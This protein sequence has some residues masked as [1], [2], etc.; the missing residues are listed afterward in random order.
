MKSMDCSLLVTKVSVSEK[1]VSL[2]ALESSECRFNCSAN[3]ASKVGDVKVSFTLDSSSGEMKIA[4][5]DRN[6]E[7]FQMIDALYQGGTAGQNG[8]ET[9]MLAVKENCLSK[10]KENIKRMDSSL[11]EYLAGKAE[12]Y[13]AAQNPYKRA[14]ALEYASTYALSRN[15]QFLDFTTL[16]G[17]CQNY[18]SQILRAGGIPNDMDGEEKWKYY[19]DAYDITG[20]AKGRTPSW[21]SVTGFLDYAQK[22]T[23]YGLSAAVGANIFTLEGGDLIICTDIRGEKVHTLAAAS[24]IYD[25]AGNAADILTFSSSI[26]RKNYPL[27]AYCYCDYTGIKILGWNE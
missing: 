15:P 14:D 22:N 2:E 8:V 23:G 27:R 13:A 12:T 21:T 19:S 18:A 7:F 4:S 20:Q 26:N 5:Y 10:V 16:G 25:E 6:D 3:T 17:N 11:A 1:T 24:L 9:A